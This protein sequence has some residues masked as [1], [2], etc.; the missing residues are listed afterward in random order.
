MPLRVA[1]IW[2]VT[3]LLAVAGCGGDDE[4]GET[5]QTEVL[6]ET[7]AGPVG[8]PALRGGDQASGTQNQRVPITADGVPTAIYAV[9]LDQLEAGVR[10][11]AIATV[12]LT[13]CAITDYVPN[14]RSFTSCEGTK[15][16]DYDPVS[17]ESSFRLVGGSGQPDLSGSGTTVGKPVKTSCTTAI[18]HCTIAQEGALELSDSEVGSDA[19]W[20]VYE[21]S[22]KA[23]KAVPCNGGTPSKCNVLAVETQKDTAMYAVRVKGEPPQSSSLPTDTT[24]DQAKLEVLTDRGDKNDVRDVVYSVPLSSA[25]DIKALEGDQMEVSALLRIEEELPQAPDIANYL[26][27][28]ASPDSIEGRYLLSD[29]YDPS[30][31]GNNGENCDDSCS[32]T[33]PAVITTI[34]DCD[35]EAGRRFVNLVADASRADARRGETV[36]VASGGLLE[37][38]Q[39]YE[40]DITSDRQ[41]VGDCNR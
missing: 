5:G 1:A 11:G 24:P 4:P 12:T 21:V 26:V 18:H 3:A 16:Y 15:V 2:L 27:L 30:K 33:R 20:L 14:A 41:S 7:D 22:A 29:S 9:K 13:K 40:A 34:L 10:V 25:A 37:V 32:F 39:Y 36:A 23:S 28:S 19:E 31:T 38:S 6:I 17:V 35:V 8:L